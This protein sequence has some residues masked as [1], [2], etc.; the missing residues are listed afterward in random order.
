MNRRDFIK[1]MGMGVAAMATPGCSST[2]QRIMGKASSKRP[3]I[4]F[5]MA[6]DLGYGHLGC[7]GQKHIQT[8][9][10][11]KMA[12]EGMHFTQ[13]YAGSSVC[14]PSRCVLMTGL[15]SGH[16]YIRNNSEVQPEGQL[17]IPAETVTVAEILKKAG[18]TTGAFGKWGLGGPNST[19]HPNKQGF[20]H[21]FGYL[22]QRHAHHFYPDY[23]WRNDTKVSLNENR[24]G[25]RGTYSHDLITKESLRFI[26][27]NKDRPFFLYLPYTIPHV[28][29]AVP[30]DSVKPYR[31]KFKEI[32]IKDPRP[33]YISSKESFATFAGMIS[34][35]DDGVGQV[36]ALLKRL[37]IDDNTI[38]FFTSDNGAQGGLWQPLV[39]M[40]DGSGPLRATKGSPYEGGI[41]VPMVVRWPGKIKSGSINSHISAFWDFLPTAAELAGIKPPKNIDGISIVPTLLGGK[42]KNHDYL[43]WE[44]RRTQAVRMGNWK[45]IRQGSKSKLELY[46]LSTDIGETTNIAN[47]NPEIVAKIE[48]YMK[49]AHTPS[50]LF[51]LL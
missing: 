11:D 8:P 21:F 23:L 42:Q 34:R 28:E 40:F 4:V 26:Q 48:E 22:C 33:G 30:E 19:G 47:Q 1:T 14:A 50:Q 3:N 43:Y 7:Y 5:I 31:G 17:P 35:M 13:H 25:K 27:A 37:N 44:R 39:K 36:M 15:H 12:T 29:L 38:V 41:R 24:D 10:I 16:A 46:D 45:G 32:L 20:D 49:T 6:D 2:L 18:Y 9:N 51:P